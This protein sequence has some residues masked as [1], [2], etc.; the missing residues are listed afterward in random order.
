VLESWLQASRRT[1]STEEITE[2]LFFAYAANPAP[3]R[4]KSAC[5]YGWLSVWD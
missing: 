2:C 1:R 5:Y 3:A 4:A